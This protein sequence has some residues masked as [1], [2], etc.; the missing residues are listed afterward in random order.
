MIACTV[1]GFFILLFID[2]D[3]L[4]SE[5]YQIRKQTLDLIQEKG[6]LIPISPIHVEDISNPK[7]IGNSKLDE[8]RMEP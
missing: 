1:L 3:K 6:E 8:G 5:D 2:G 4:Q 7:R